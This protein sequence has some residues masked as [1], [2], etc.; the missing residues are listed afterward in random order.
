MLKVRPVLAPVQ[1]AFA[2]NVVETDGD[3]AEID[4]HLTEAEEARAARERGQA[5]IDHRPRHHKHHFYIEEDEE[6]RHQIK[7]HAE[8]PARVAGSLNTAFV[9]SEL[10]RSIAM[11]A[12][13][14]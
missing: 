12:H 1:D 4:Q 11:A 2:H 13:K 14:P 9:G 5:A 8:T 3:K 7:A 10:D 6:N